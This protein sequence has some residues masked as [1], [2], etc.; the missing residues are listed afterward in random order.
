MIP[1]KRKSDNVIGLYDM[2]SRQFFTNSGTGS[3]TG[4]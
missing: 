2:V 4:A 1:A 3:F